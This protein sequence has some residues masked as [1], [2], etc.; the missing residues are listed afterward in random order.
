MCVY[1]VTCTNYGSVLHLDSN[2]FGIATVVNDDI[3]ELGC[4][5]LTWLMMI[6]LRLSSRSSFSTAKVCKG[7][8]EFKKVPCCP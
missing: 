7:F 6:D 8:R 2:R 3:V 5:S 1:V 4:W